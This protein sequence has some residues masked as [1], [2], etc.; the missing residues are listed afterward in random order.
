MNRFEAIVRLPRLITMRIEPG[1]LSRT[2]T[3]IGRWPVPPK[4]GRVSRAN[5]MSLHCRVA[6]KRR[7]TRKFRPRLRSAIRR[8][9][10]IPPR[11]MM[12]R[13]K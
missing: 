12:K 6:W 7:S 10:L 9:S 1:A 3:R 11:R 4:T 13:A 2:E 5:L 8:A